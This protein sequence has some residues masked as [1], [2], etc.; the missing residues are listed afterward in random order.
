MSAGT[1]LRASPIMRKGSAFRLSSCRG[2]AAHQDCPHPASRCNVIAA[3]ANLSEALTT[4]QERAHGDGLAFVHPF[5]DPAVIA[6]QGTLGLEILSQIGDLNVIVVSIG[7]GGLISG[8]AT[9]AKAIRPDIKVIGVQSRTYPSMA[10][11]LRG[12]GDSL[13]RCMTIAEGIAAKIAGM[14]TRG[15]VSAHVDDI[16]LAD[17]SSIERAIAQFEKTIVEGAGAVGIAAIIEHPRIFAGRR[18]T[19]ILMGSN[20]DARLYASVVMRDLVPTGQPMRIAVPISDQPGIL[21]DIGDLARRARRQCRRGRARTTG[22][23][24]QSKGTRFPISCWIAGRQ[25]QQPGAASVTLSPIS[26]QATVYRIAWRRAV[27]ADRVDQLS[28]I[29]AKYT[30]VCLSLIIGGPAV[31]PQS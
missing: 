23:F 15:I 19:I 26:C 9:A 16:L 30:M 13:Q 2:H 7:G 1:M 4:A 20:I 25:P 8:I 29:C 31:D 14:L 28:L 5:D 11:A 27:A 22:A 6:G 3:G 24:P 18:V 17:E 10:H 12:L 21:D